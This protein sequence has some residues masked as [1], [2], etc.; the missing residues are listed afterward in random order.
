MCVE[1]VCTGGVDVHVLLQGDRR[2]EH[3]PAWKAEW[4]KNAEEE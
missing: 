3:T 4:S 1:H 2:T